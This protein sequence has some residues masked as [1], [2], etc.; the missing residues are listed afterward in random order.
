MK[1]ALLGLENQTDPNLDMP[2]R[3]IG[4]DGAAYRTQLIDKKSKDR[5]PVLSI[6]LYF[7]NPRWSGPKSINE[8]VT[9]PAGMEMIIRFMSLR[10]HI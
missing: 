10:W 3:I 4:Y 1:I 7:G 9:I 8:M 2:F 6:V 5:C